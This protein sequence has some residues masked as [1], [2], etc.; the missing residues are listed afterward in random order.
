MDA[1]AEI[2]IPMSQHIGAHCTPAVKVGERV[3]RGQVIGEVSGLGCPVHSS[4]SGTV[5]A[6]TS[7]NN[8]QAQPIQ[9]V[10]IE[11]DGLYEMHP[12]IKP[13][14]KKLTEAT[15]DE[16]IEAVRK[17][18]ISGMGG[19]T[20]PTHAKIRSAIGKVDRLIINCAECEPFIT[21]NHRLMLERPAE[22]INGT[23]ILLK[24]L[25]LR[26]ADIAI[27]DNKLDAAAKLEERIGASRMINIR[28]M[29][30]KYPQGDE[31]Q[32]IYA[33][34]GKEVP[35]GKLP[36]DVGCVIFN[37]ETCAAIYRAFALGMPLI[38]R[39]VTV[40][41]DCIATPKNLLVPIGTSYKDVID[42]C[43]GLKK[44]PKKIVSGGPMMGFAQWNINSP[45]VKG[46]SAILVLSEKMCPEEKNDYAC[47][48][49][50]RCVKNCPMHLMPNYLAQFAQRGKH[51]E[52]ENYDVMSCV[53][54]GTCTYNCPAHV[55]IVQYIR[56]S[57]GALRAKK[58]AES[59]RAASNM[60]DLD[61][62]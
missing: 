26:E 25:G 58:A 35:Q 11:N 23:K 42:F 39:I 21:A 10:V 9:T 36:A 47:I 34:T 44:E 38:E 5:K 8:A 43:G 13:C 29:K 19:A 7:Y 20:F 40:D 1:P 54:C 16:I 17:A 15:A 3:L 50:G 48:R 56:V 41:G 55:P 18:G 52:A 53:E 49:C 46:T 33:L 61:K 6:I 2:S 60:P 37:A 62:K 27:E 4:V 12:D 45:V 22:I 30:T 24:A 31:R 14:E 28:I 32:L 57:K 51:D 59:A